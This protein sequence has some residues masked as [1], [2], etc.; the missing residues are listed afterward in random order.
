MT[1]PPVISKPP[2]AR[3]LFE[4]D[5]SIR[6]GARFFET[7]PETLR[8]CVLPYGDPHQRQPHRALMRRIIER[9]G[10]AIRPN[11]WYADALEHAA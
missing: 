8:R 1:A 3:W 2:L 4:R 10:G 7:T 11:D 6:D 5:M 9:T